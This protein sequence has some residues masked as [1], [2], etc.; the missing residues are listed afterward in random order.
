MNPNSLKALAEHRN[1]N[2]Q[3]SA[4]VAAFTRGLRAALATEA[5]QPSRARR[6]L[7]RYQSMIRKVWD[8]AEK[9]VPWAVDYVSERV[10]GKVT[11][12]IG[13]DASMPFGD[14]TIPIFKHEDRPAD[15]AS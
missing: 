4:V 7:T 6:G 12:P 3:T 15:G 13:M 14:T 8:L 11:Q 10:E 5:E 9:G 2:G 1:T